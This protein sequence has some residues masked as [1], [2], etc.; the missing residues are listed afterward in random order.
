MTDPD[1]DEWEDCSDDGSL[2]E[3]DEVDD[4]EE[5]VE[6]IA[7]GT[8]CGPINEYLAEAWID[9]EYAEGVATSVEEDYNPG[10]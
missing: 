2:A 5:P 10:Q 8:P 4:S 3:E 7:F 9:G 1:I 6:A